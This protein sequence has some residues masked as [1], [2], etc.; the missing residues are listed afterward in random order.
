MTCQAGPETDLPSNRA[1]SLAYPLAQAILWL[2]VLSMGFCETHVT[3][4]DFRH[5]NTNAMTRT[6]VK[7]TALDQALCSCFKPSGP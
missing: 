6:P 5:L 3:T 4:G 1:I 2:V 7:R